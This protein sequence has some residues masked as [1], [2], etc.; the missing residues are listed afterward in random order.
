MANTVF[1]PYRQWAAL[2]EVAQRLVTSASADLAASDLDHLRPQLEVLLNEGVLLEDQGR[3]RFFHENMLDHVFARAFAEEAGSIGE[4]LESNPQGPIQRSDVRRVLVY[5]RGISRTDYTATV[6]DVLERDGIRFLIKDAV[7]GVMRGDPAPTEADWH[8]ISRFVENTE[9]PEHSAALSVASQPPWFD[10]L[11][12]SARVIRWLG[13]ERD[14]ERD[15]ATNLLQRVQGARGPR[16]ATL[17]AP[18]VSLPEWHDRVRL[19]M[20]SSAP[21]SDRRI[22]ELFLEAVAEGAYDDL[23]GRTSAL[24]WITGRDL[25]S[26]KPSWGAELLRL[27]LD[28]AVGDG[29]GPPSEWFDRAFSADDF[30]APRYLTV[31]AQANARAYAGVALPF[32]LRA[33]DES[34]TPMDDDGVRLDSLW[35]YRYFDTGRSRGRETLFTALDSALRDLAMNRPRSL[36]PFTRRLEKHL[37]FETARVLL[38]RA[39]AAHAELFWPDAMRVLGHSPT[40]FRTGG[41]FND[42]YWETRELIRAV[43]PY[44]DHDSMTHLEGRILDYVSPSETSVRARDRRGYAQFVLL[45]ALGEQGLSPAGTARLSEL[46][47]KFGSAPSGPPKIVTGYVKPPIDPVD[48]SKMSDAQWLKAIRTY[49]SEESSGLLKGGAVELSRVLEDEVAKDPARFATL[50]LK[51]TDETNDHY[52]DAV[53]RGLGNAEE[54]FEP[55]SLF[56]ALRHFHSLVGR[57]GGRWITRPLAHVANEDVPDDIVHIAAWYATEDPDPSRDLWRATAE[58]D[59]V[60]YGGDAFMAGLNT[61]RGAAAEA[62]SALIWPNAARI[63]LLSE[64]LNALARDPSIAVRTCAAEAFSSVYRHDPKYALSLFN[65][66]VDTDDVLLATRPVEQFLSLSTRRHFPALRPVLTRMLASENSAVQQAGGRQAA[67]AALGDQRGYDLVETAFLLG[68]PVRTGIAEVASHNIANADVRERCAAWLVKLFGDVA[69]SVREQA[70]MWCGSLTSTDLRELHDLALTYVESEAHVDNESWLF[71]ALDEATV[72]V[73]DIA[74]R[75]IERFL[76][77]HEHEVVDISTAAAADASTAARLAVRAYAS[78]STIALRER[79]LDLIER[80]LIARISDIAEFVSQH[81]S[82][83]D[84]PELEGT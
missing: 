5:Q 8:T 27:C 45:D 16:V 77:H 53:L 69:D 72:P 84:L 12:R 22:F 66:L 40:P 61:A 55:Q 28:R 75:A 30:W 62:L 41:H 47:R 59:T 36:R 71:N 18:F 44:A 32:V 1:D 25:A 49:E 82:I 4:W 70:A 11:D 60:F 9:A 29:L 74:V 50:A 2:K 78:A 73:A 58:G 6:A 51:F 46:R 13:S 20:R 64:S 3:I 17:L 10:L 83:T 38:Y 43:Q 19:L 80:L 54:G 39:W 42:P 21:A 81:D 14:S 26:R 56:A 65:V 35:S 48:A 67:L 37:G 33:L 31:L 79:A 63:P 68:I 24:T 15:L 76:E 7:L 34:E 52:V 57:P 23:G